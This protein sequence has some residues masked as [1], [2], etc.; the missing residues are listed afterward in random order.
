MKKSFIASDIMFGVA[1]LQLA[2]TAPAQNGPVSNQSL[3][4]APAVSPY[5][6]LGYSANGLSN[7]QSLVKPMIDEREDLSRQSV[8]LQQL[9]RQLR[10]GQGAEDPANRNRKTRSQ[11]TVRFMHYSHFYEG[12]RST[13]K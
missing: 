6:N 9:Q 5:L 12:L 4:S 2:R 1:W 10:N 7:Y 8:S 11:T 3:Y 13:D